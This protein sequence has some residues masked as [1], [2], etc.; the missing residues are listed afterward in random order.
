MRAADVLKM[1]LYAAELA[2]GAKSFCDNPLIGSRRLN[3]AGLHVKRIKLAEM[4]V[5]DG[6]FFA[7]WRTILR[8]VAPLLLLVVLI[9]GIGE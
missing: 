7:F 5:A 3:E 8:Y 1:P 4:D 9:M 2:T 6:A